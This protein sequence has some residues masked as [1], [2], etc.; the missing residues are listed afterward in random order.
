MNSL[1]AAGGLMGCA[2]A[3]WLADKVGRKV[4]IQLITTACILAAAFTTGSQNVAML[5]SGRALQ[6]IA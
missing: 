3:G 1:Y 6:G 2:I 4:S 5:L